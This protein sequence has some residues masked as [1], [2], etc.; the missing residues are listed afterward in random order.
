MT[1]TMGDAA[2]DLA[3]A[4]WPVFPLRG[5]LPWIAKRD[6]GRGLHDGTT[7]VEQV[8]AWWDRWPRANIGARVPDALLVVDVDPRHLGDHELAALE[9]THGPLPPTLTVWSGRGD[10]GKHLYWQHPGGKVTDT[11]LPD[12]VDLR[13]GGA[14]YCVMPPSIHPDSSRPYRWDNPAVAVAA[15]PVWLIGLLRPPR[16]TPVR[17]RP[18]EARKG[19]GYGAAAL[20]GEAADVAATREGGR[21][22]RLYLAA[23]RLGQLVASGHCTE[24]EV[25]A[26]LAAAAQ[27]CG[28][29]PKAAGWTISSGLKFGQDH[30][31]GAP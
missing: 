22:K 27:A 17:V 30:P 15:A 13:N 3:A 12:G 28:L 10:G 7:N 8:A 25:R 14:S 6:G 19:G 29:Q 18:P 21:N 23:I 24:T 11:G 31:R 16:P 9:A 26:E 5:K 1:E 20:A 4:G 2:L